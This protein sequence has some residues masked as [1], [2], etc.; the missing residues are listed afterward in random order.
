MEIIIKLKNKTIWYFLLL[1][2]FLTYIIFLIIE[3]GLELPET[4]DKEVIYFNENRL[5]HI[6]RFVFRFK[7]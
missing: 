5:I 3:F 2:L 6:E 4:N 7:V 1:A